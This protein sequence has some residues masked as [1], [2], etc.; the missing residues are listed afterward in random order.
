MTLNTHV[1]E[2]I[3]PSFI[4][5]ALEDGKHSESEIVEVGDAVVRAFPVQTA[6]LTRRF[7]TLETGITA[8]V[9]FFECKQSCK[10]QW[11]KMKKD[12]Q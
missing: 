6:H 8:W 3:G 9:G 2:D 10:T 1:I 12:N 4:G 7:V 5:D 11:Q